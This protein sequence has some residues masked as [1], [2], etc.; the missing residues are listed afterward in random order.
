[1]SDEVQAIVY[2]LA[3]RFYTEA[4]YFGTLCAMRTADARA[5]LMAGIGCCGCAAPLA[6]AQRLLEG[7]PE[8]AQAGT[9]DL[10]ISPMTRLPIEGFY[11]LLEARRLD[12]T[13]MVPP[14]L[15]AIADEVADDLAFAS[16]REIHRRPDRPGRYSHRLV[17]VAAALLLRDMTGTV[18]ALPGVME[19]TRTVAQE[20]IAVELAQTGGDASFLEVAQSP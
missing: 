9:S 3:N 14:D 19:P 13:I 12:R 8:R 16:R 11:H 2:L 18:D 4:A 15:R 7:V 6:D 1:M 5:H 10:N 20:A 17:C